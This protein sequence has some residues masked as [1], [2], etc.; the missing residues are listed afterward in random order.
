M[1]HDL[2]VLQS[3][4]EPET[5]RVYD[6]LHAHETE[7]GRDADLEPPSRTECRTQVCECIS[8]C[9]YVYVPLDW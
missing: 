4:M 2:R 8:T 3:E 1:N 5:R 9:A 6:E 7:F